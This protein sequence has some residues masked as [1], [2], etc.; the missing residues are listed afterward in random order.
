MCY[1]F[2]FF[3]SSRRRHTRCYRDWSSD[4]CSSD[5]DEES[6]L[7]RAQALEYD[8]ER[9]H[10]VVVVEGRGRAD[11]DADPLFQAVRRAAGYTGVGTLLVSRTGTVVLL[12]NQDLDWEKLR[13]AVLHELGDGRVRI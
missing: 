9:S 5:L 7:A 2:F 3:F 12:A 6:A 1:W 10:R 13:E 8:L 4:V 11:G